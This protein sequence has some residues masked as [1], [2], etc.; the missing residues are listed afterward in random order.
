VSLAPGHSATRHRCLGV[1]AFPA[2]TLPLT[3]CFAWSGIEP[4]PFNGLGIVFPLAAPIASTPHAKQ[5]LGLLA[6]RCNQ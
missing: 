2:L 4:A 5:D 6:A 3:K 1:V